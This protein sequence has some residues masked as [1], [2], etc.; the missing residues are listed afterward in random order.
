MKYSYFDLSR[1]NLGMNTSTSHL[2]SSGSWS[3][4]LG[5]VL[6]RET[7]GRAVVVV[8]GVGGAVAAKR[9]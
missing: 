6:K 5:F 1:L 9:V 7:I 3:L 4:D 2:G 8:L